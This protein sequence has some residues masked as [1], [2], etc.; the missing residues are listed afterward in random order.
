MFASLKK[1]KV[2]GLTIQNFKEKYPQ[3]TLCDIDEETP[4]DWRY[5]RAKVKL[6]GNKII[7]LIGIS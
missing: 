5:W 2:E 6:Q 3:Y 4:W 1:K 7:K